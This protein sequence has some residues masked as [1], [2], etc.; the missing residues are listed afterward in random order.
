MKTCPRCQVPVGDKDEY[1][2][3]G[4][5]IDE[6]LDINIIYDLLGIDKPA[7]E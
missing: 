6:G 1:C 4:H 5:K 7:K 3:N 2:V